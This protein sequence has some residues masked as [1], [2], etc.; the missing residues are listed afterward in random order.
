MSKKSRAFQF[1]GLPL[2]FFALALSAVA[3]PAA[4]SNAPFIVNSWSTEEGLPDSEVISVI[5]THDGYLWLGTLHGLVRFDGIHFTPFDEM[6]TPGLNSDR[7]VYLFEDSRTNLWVGTESSGLSVIQDGKVKN[8]GSESGAGGGKPVYAYEDATTNVWFY[9][10]EG[11][12]FRYHDGRMDSTVLSAQL[13]FRAAKIQVPGKSGFWQIMNGTVQKWQDNRPE[14]DYGPCPWGKMVVTAACED[15]DGNLIVGTLGGGVFW[16]EADGQCWHISTEQGLSS[17]YVLSLCMDRGGNLW[18]GTDGSGLNRIKRKTFDT[19]VE[20]H[21]WDAQS[22][23]ADSHGGLWTA[24]NAHGMSYWTT[25]SV[26]D[27]AIG[28]ASNA[29]TVLVDKKQRVWAGT[30][31]EGLF[32]LQDNRFNPPPGAEILGSRIF[33]FFEDRSGQLWVGAENGLGCWNGLNW[34]L[35]TTRDGLSQN[36]VRAIAEDAA[37]NLWIGTE[38]RGLD[39]FKDGKFISY[40]ADGNGLPGDDISCLYADKDGVL[41][42]GTGGH[43]LARLENGKWARYAT[44]NG[45]ASDSISY[46]TEDDEGYLWI[47][48]NAGLMRIPKQSL[49]DFSAGTT[50]AISCRTYGKADGLPT[51]ECSAGSQPTACRTADGRLWFPTIK[52]LASVNPADL[53]PNLQTPLVMIESIL[54]DGREQKTNRLDPAWPPSITIPPGGEELEIHYTALNFSAPEL[55]RFKCWL[56]DHETAPT[57]VG[58]ER[59]ARYPKLPPGHYRF[60][61]QACNEDNIWSGP[62]AAVLSITVQPQFWQTGW[63][64]VAAIVLILGIVAAIVRYISTQKLQRQLQL[65]QQREALEKER[66]RIARDLHD[67]LGA[68][69]TQVALLGEMAEADKDSPA[70]IESHAQQISQTARETTRSLDEIVWAVNPANDTLDGLVNYAG[71]YAQEYLALAGLRYRADLPAQLPA[72]PIPPEVRHNVFLAFKEAVHN[73]VKHAQATEA[74]IR[75][76]LQPENFIL[77]IEDNGYGTGNQTALQ[78]RNGLRNMKKRMEDI[79]GEFSIAPGANGGTIVRLT[80]PII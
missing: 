11:R 33:A 54:V 32:Q 65:L 52:G 19:P 8:F 76:R 46:I 57:D 2:C 27:F 80:V 69:L 29:W 47:G 25:N 64:R 49:N 70:E 23:S 50:N 58:E 72:I 14:K 71:K 21:L 13:L 9:T 75:L 44:T 1:A 59:I 3:G 41:W 35:F 6:N 55:V 16:Y 20:L 36:A 53:K 40:R 63:F 42:V 78:N 22:L 17:A 15:K 67:Q 39:F 61:I 51:R 26:Q 73:V 66:A 24:F 60:H 56:E 7:I 4:E 38:N 48:S 28:Q 77:E 5:Q 79:R 31:G 30:L 18:V 45:L 37:G 34:K 12:S 74:R 68:N 62:D 10:A 43:G